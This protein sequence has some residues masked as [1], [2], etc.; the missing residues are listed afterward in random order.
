MFTNIDHMAICVKNLNESIKKY[1]GDLG[2]SYSYREIVE[3]QGVEVAFFKTN[4]INIELIQPLTSTNPVHKYIEKK[5]EGLHHIAFQVDDIEKS[6]FEL[7]K[8]Q[9]NLIHH[10]PR[11]GSEGSKVAFIHP[12][13]FGVLI[14]IVQKRGEFNEQV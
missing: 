14:E 13:Q 6:L 1:E 3:D 2:L 7:K 11:N 12:K 10:S 4:K 8:R 9:F 5:G